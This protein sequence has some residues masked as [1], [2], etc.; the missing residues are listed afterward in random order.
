MS[1]E[2]L[3]RSYKTLKAR[4]EPSPLGNTPEQSESGRP[5]LW[6]GWRTRANNTRGNGRY[7]T[8][9]TYQTNVRTC[10]GLN[11]QGC[12]VLWADLSDLRYVVFEKAHATRRT[13]ERGHNRRTLNHGHRLQ[14][15]VF[16]SPA[17]FRSSNWSHCSYH[18]RCPA[19]NRC[20][21]GD[22]ADTRLLPQYTSPHTKPEQSK[23]DRTQWT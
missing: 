18:L 15:V 7:G 14:Q 1:R 13:E 20:S 8:S 10:A 9:H 23:A 16:R 4:G 21:P 5:V 17:L 19:S 3:A 6:S 12:L 2:I 22:T 11:F